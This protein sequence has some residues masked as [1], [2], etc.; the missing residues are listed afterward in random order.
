MDPSWITIFVKL[1][2]YQMLPVT[3]AHHMK[4]LTIFFF[5]CDKY[6]DNREILFNSLNWLPSNINV[7]RKSTDKRKWFPNI[8]RKYNYF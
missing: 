3:V 1:K 8:S 5:D 2:F 7:E 6:I 4:I